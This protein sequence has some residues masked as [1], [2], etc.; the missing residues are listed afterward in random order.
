[1]EHRLV[2]PESNYGII[3][4]FFFVLKGSFIFFILQGDK[5]SAC[6]I[7]EKAIAAEKEKDR[8]Q[9]LPTLLIQYSRFLSLVSVS[10]L[11]L[12]R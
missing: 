7:Y 10:L 6:S 9:I 11:L 5:E 3:V 2:S 8:S 1:M 12:L 4:S